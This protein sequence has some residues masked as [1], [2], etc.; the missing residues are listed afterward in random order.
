MTHSRI[1]LLALG[2]ILAPA[3]GSAQDRDLEAKLPAPVKKTFRTEFPRAVIEKLDV[4]E[5]GGVT[6]YDLECRDGTIEKETDITADGTM[7]EFTVVIEAKDVPEAAMKPIRKAAQGATMKRIER[8]EI[9]YETKHGKTIKLP[10]PVTRYAVEL[11]KGTRRAEIV[12]APDGKEIEP[13]RWG[14]GK[15]ESKTPSTGPLAKAGIR[16]EQLNLPPGACGRCPCDGARVPR[17]RRPG[18][19]R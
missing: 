13:A 10:K 4:E 2:V 9:S 5:E 15:E 3:A 11:S 1:V 19:G 16:E 18:P 14:G 12:V 6:V 17:G 8:I 7:L